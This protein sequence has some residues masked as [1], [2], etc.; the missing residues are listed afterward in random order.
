MKNL[1]VNRMEKTSGGVR[2]G[3]C[4]F[5]LAAGVALGTGVIAS[6]GIFE[7]WTCIDCYLS[8]VEK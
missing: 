6:V 4:G 3:S 7:L 5:C 1:D 8:A 2:W